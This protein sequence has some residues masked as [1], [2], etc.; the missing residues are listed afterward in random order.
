[1]L[2]P[3]SV[4]Y[5]LNILTNKSKIRDVCEFKRCIC[6]FSWKANPE[7]M[8][9]SICTKKKK[10][11]LFF[12][13]LLIQLNILKYV[14]CGLCAWSK[15]TNSYFVNQML[16]NEVFPRELQNHSCLQKTFSKENHLTSQ[17]EKDSLKICDV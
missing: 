10:K 11:N 17:T 7:F 13:I 15:L 14:L 2:K 6:K 16:R 3:L 8:K 9:A 4:Y 12:R 5:L 1:M